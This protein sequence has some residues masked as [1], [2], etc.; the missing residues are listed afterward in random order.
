MCEK[1]HRMESA[2]LTEQD[3]LQTRTGAVMKNAQREFCS[4]ALNKTC[5]GCDMYRDREVYK[6][7]WGT[8]AVDST[9]AI[10]E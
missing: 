7:A 4:G 3:L 9:W 8:G 5:A 6:T 10:S 2:D 1:H